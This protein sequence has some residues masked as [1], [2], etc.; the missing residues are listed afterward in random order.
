[1]TTRNALVVLILT[2]AGLSAGCPKPDTVP[3]PETDTLLPAVSG[4]IVM[5]QP[6]GGLTAVQL[7]TLQETVIRRPAPE[8]QAEYP[9]VLALSGPDENGRIAYF[10][11][12]L[13]VENKKDQRHLLKTIR[14]DGQN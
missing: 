3:G 4:F 2:A 14:V 8:G 11:D 6:L 7:P 1:M 5:E 13:A 10:D 12:Y 9:V